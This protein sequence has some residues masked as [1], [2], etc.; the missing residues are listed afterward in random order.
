[1]WKSNDIQN[2]GLKNPTD[3][4]RVKTNQ[5]KAVCNVLDCFDTSEEA[6]LLSIIFK[7]LWIDILVW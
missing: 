3:L 2:G 6:W 4:T 1:M 7:G 5:Y